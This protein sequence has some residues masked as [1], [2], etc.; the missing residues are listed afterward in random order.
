MMGVVGEFWRDLLRTALAKSSLAKKPKG[1]RFRFGRL[2]KHTRQSH[3]RGK[4]HIYVSI[5]S[6]CANAPDLLVMYFQIFPTAGLNL[7]LKTTPTRQVK[8]G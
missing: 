5:R 2:A 1:M 7:A 3:T 6:G 4:L 8:L